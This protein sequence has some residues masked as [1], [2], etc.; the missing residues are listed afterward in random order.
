[1]TDADRSA[2]KAIIDFCTDRWVE[3]DREPAS[4]YQPPGM[5]TGRKS[6]NNDVLEPGKAKR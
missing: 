1:M 5:L 6:A 2:L 3:A 4:Q